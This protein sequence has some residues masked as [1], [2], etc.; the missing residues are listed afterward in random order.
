M[1]YLV[2]HRE[3][4]ISKGNTAAFLFYKPNLYRS[5]CFFFFFFLELM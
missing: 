1:I 5:V 2:F 3:N 4:L